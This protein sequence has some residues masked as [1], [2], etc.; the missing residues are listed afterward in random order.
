MISLTNLNVDDRQNKKHTFCKNNYIHRS[1]RK[2]QNL[3]LFQNIVE[4]LLNA[5]LKLVF[6]TLGQFLQVIQF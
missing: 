1:Y 2:A 6:I 5:I 3:K 4:I